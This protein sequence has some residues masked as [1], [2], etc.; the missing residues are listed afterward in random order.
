AVLVGWLWNIGMLKSI[1]DGYISMKFNTGVSFLLLSVCLIISSLTK[2]NSPAVLTLEL[3]VAV[4][5]L[6]SLSQEIF[7]VNLGIDELLYPDV[8]G[9]LKNEVYPGRM[10][11]ITAVLFAVMALSMFGQ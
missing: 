1:L 5:A 8:D 4:Y 3:L 2:K 10:S 6:V 11:P 9:F 7:A